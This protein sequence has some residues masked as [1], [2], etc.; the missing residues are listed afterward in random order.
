MA[1]TGAAEDQLAIR[2]LHDA[3]ADAVFQRDAQLWGDNWAADARWDLMGTSVAGRDAIV[4]LWVQAMAGFQFVGF[5]SQVGRL[6][7]AGDQATGR[8]FTHE[9]LELGDGTIS[10]PVGRYDDNYIKVDGRWLF[11]ARRYSLLKG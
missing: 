8:V 11:K 4:A 5:F 7:I 3:Y 2:N 10:R 9:V 1:F 6:E